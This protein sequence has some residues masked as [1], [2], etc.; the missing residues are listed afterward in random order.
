M[1]PGMSSPTRQLAA[2]LVA[3]G[4]TLVSGCGQSALEV[5]PASDL[6]PSPEDTVLIGCWGSPRVA[7]VAVSL[8]CRWGA[9][10]LQL[11]R[12]HRWGGRGTYATGVVPMYAC[13]DRCLAST[14]TTA[15]VRV[16]LSGLSL[17]DDAT[18]AYATAT[19]T[20]S[21]PIP[22]WAGERR[23]IYRLS[24]GQLRPLRP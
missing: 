1:A 9:P 16:E 18:A 20:A 10:R 23:A 14:R 7:P 4:A 17:L 5:R 15:T 12:W 13:T 22:A 8:D 6:A 2:A 19:L 3:A 21:R 24:V 11:L